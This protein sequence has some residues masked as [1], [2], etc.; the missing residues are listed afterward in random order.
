MLSRRDALRSTALCLLAGV[1]GV[2]C[3]KDP[4]FSC[5][6]INGI[7]PPDVALRLS[8]G[9]VDTSPDSGK[10]CRNCTQYVAA[11]G[12]ERGAC[13]SCRLMKGPIHPRGYCR[14]YTA[15]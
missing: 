14:V 1:A 3:K 6:D 5:S 13:G 10:E 12:N 8:L 15:A 4:P 7:A 9:Y 11:A 2:G